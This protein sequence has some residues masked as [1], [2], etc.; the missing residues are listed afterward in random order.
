MINLIKNELIKIFSKKAIYIV[1]L[2]MFLFVI[3]VNCI[4]KFA[5]DENGYMKSDDY[6]EQDL[7][8]LNEEIIN[9]DINNPD[10]ISTYI[11][12]KTNIEVDELILKYGV[13][14]WQSYVI[15]NTLYDVIYNINVDKYGDKKDS[16]EMA[17]LN[18]QYNTAL[19]KF[20]SGDWQYYTNIEL[21]NINS[22]LEIIE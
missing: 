19:E 8:Y 20:E 3:L 14:S 2:I 7:N 1:L 21:D 15:N 10:D 18:S 6:T 12:I 4:Y 13:D 22:Q 17:L 9:L 5:Y 16:Y 11:S